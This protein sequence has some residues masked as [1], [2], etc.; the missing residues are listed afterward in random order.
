MGQNTFQSFQ[1][2]YSDYAVTN[3]IPGQSVFIFMCSSFHQ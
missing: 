1:N 2:A 3:G